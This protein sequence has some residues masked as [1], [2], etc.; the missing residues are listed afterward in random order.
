MLKGIIFDFDGVI[1]ESADIKTEA[2]LELFSNYPEHREEIL[3]HH[4]ENQG[5]SRYR[6]FEWIYT[7]LLGKELNEEESC[8]LGETF[9]GI[10]FERILACSFVPGAA[11][12]LKSLDGRCAMFVAS[13]TPQE[14]LDRI[15][16]F[17]GL[18]RYFRE[19]WGTPL[20][21][22]EIIRSILE[23]HGFEAEDVMFVGDGLSDYH[24]AREAGVPF[25]ARI[26]PAADSKW[27]ELGVEGARDLHEFYLSKVEG[28]VS[29][30]EEA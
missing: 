3:K 20:R 2:F 5:I 26:V 16:E 18:S 17:K 28:L 11:E 23:R 9:S 21:K 14:E 27:Q 13:G 12:L 24:A 25:F 19:A 15:I 4:L 1:L 22:V 7:Q 29:S 8:Q 30:R 10:V 6:K